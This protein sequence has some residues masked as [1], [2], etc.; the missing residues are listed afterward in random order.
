MTLVQ[1]SARKMCSPEECACLYNV[2]FYI[3]NYHPK[4]GRIKPKALVMGNYIE[5]IVT[6]NKV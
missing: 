2:D 1:F 4:Y 5:L 3:L 6:G